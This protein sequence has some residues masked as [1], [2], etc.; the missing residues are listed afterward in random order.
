MGGSSRTGRKIKGALT[1]AL[2]LSIAKPNVRQGLADFDDEHAR[3]VA[4]N[5]MRTLLE[6]QRIRSDKTR[7][8]NARKM[9]L[10]HSR[11]MKKVHMA[12]KG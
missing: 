12:G 10:L 3:H 9:A 1:P 5:D 6:A 4:E 2:G 11:L 7:H 8:R